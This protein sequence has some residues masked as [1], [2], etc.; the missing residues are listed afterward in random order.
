MAILVRSTVE[1]SH[2]YTQD[3]QSCH[4]IKRANGDGDRPVTVTD[5]RKLKLLPSV[6]NILGVLHKPQLENHKIAS[7][8]RAAM[9]SP[10]S[11][12]ES[13]EYYIKRI[14][15]AS[16]EDVRGAADLGTRIHDA[17]DMALYNAEYDATLTEYV[18]PVMQVISDRKWNLHTREVV[19]VNAYEGYAGRVDAIYDCNEGFGIIDF[20]TRKTKPNQKCTPYDGQAEQLAA[21]ARAH[22]GKDASEIA[23]LINI[24]I[25]TTEPGRVEVY[26]HPDSLDYWRQ[27]KAAATIWRGMKNYDPRVR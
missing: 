14:I 4:T 6:T 16:K 26:E 1:G 25:S 27:F 17:I 11:A 7:A 24:Y 10:K 18:A 13:E 15:D 19:L 20:K 12:E 2:W 21:Y 5:A 22:Y 3:G 23:T 9:A 8:V